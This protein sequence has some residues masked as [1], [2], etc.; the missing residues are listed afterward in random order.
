MIFVLISFKIY[1]HYL[2]TYNNNY[3]IKAKHQFIIFVFHSITYVVILTYVYNT[4]GANSWLCK[5]LQMLQVFWT[6]SILNSLPID[7]NLQ[8]RIC[9]YSLFIIISELYRYE[10]FSF[11]VALGYG[12]VQT[13]SRVRGKCKWGRMYREG[14][15]GVVASHPFQG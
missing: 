5:H 14:I 7:K 2:R 15:F 6:S 3:S 11:S 12:D 13:S 9:P 1:K 4:T 10:K 8:K